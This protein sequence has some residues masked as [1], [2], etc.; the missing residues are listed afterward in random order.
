MTAMLESSRGWMIATDLTLRATKVTARSLGSVM[1]TIVVQ[2]CHLWLVLRDADKIQ[3]LNSPV[4]QTGL[5]SNTV[6]SFAQQFLAAQK[7]AEAIKHILPR[8]TAAASI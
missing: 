4:S 8:R 2:E 5:F 6:E 7:Q 1:S 3:F